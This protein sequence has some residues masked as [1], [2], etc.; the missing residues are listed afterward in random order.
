MAVEKRKSPSS[1]LEIV[2]PFPKAISLPDIVRSPLT[3]V[4]VA[5][6]ARVLSVEF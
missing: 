1:S 5:V 6:I 2:S 4:V 3:D